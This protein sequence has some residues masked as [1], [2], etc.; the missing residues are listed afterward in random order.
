MDIDNG[1]I[2]QGPPC[3]HDVGR[4]QLFRTANSRGNYMEVIARK[5]TRRRLSA[6]GPG[7]VT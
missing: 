4:M 2:A 3:S 5:Y 1:G 6:H 7:V